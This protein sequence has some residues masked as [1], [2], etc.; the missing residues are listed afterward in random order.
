MNSNSFKVSRNVSRPIFDC[1][2]ND[3]GNITI[4]L[5]DGYNVTLRT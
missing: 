1:D 2:T 4:H 5:Y 3:D